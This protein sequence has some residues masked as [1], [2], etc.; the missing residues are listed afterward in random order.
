MGGGVTKSA[1]DTNVSKS[2]CYKMYNTVPRTTASGS[3]AQHPRGGANLLV[4]ITQF[5]AI[6][7]LEVTAQLATLRGIDRDIAVGE[8]Y[9]SR[10]KDW[11]DSQIYPA[12]DTDSQGEY[13]PCVD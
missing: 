11:P 4:V 5:A 12:V 9:G 13:P 8:V 6:I 10:T 1:H 7:V 2:T 3:L